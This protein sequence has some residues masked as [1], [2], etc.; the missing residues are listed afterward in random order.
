MGQRGIV[1]VLALTLLVGQFDSVF[2]QDRVIVDRREKGYRLRASSAWTVDKL[3]AGEDSSI[4]LADPFC[5][6]SVI[7]MPASGV[8][9]VTKTLLKKVYEQS[10]RG[11]ASS[12]VL[13]QKIETH[14]G[15]PSGWIEFTGVHKEAPDVQ[16]HCRYYLTLHRDHLY[17]IM[18]M[19]T[20]DSW[21][22]SWPH[23]RRV[24]QSMEFL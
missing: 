20:E 6:V 12:D 5:H 17:L 14:R 22:E 13:K 4:K 16:F 19:S 24:L 23:G 2:A 15:K 3:G 10:K 1:P 11:F 8:D 9:R 18:I 21:R 7:V